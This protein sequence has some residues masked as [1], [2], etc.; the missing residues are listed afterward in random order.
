MREIL[1]RGKAI[2]DINSDLTVN[3]QW[4][5]GYYAKIKPCTGIYGKKEEY[6]EEEIPKIISGQE[7]IT[8]NPNTIGQYTGLKDKNGKKIFE[9]DIVDLSNCRQIPFIY[10][11]I[12][13]ISVVEWEKY[14]A[15][16]YPFCNYD[17]DCGTSVCSEEV[18]VIGNVFDN[19]DVV[20]FVEALEKCEK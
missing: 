2:K 10:D 19:P 6:I 1:F 13:K 4:V 16:F 12:G 11:E 18:K 8:V 3:T 15:G 5:Y 20:K 9:G 17:K 7:A 14:Y